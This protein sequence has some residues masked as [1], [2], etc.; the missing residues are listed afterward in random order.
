VQNLKSNVA[1]NIAGSSASKKAC[2]MQASVLRQAC[3]ACITYACVW[4]HLYS[5]ALAKKTFIE[6]FKIAAQFHEHYGTVV[7]WNVRLFNITSNYI[8]VRLELAFCARCGQHT[9][10]CI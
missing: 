5:S 4:L 2:V 1:I 9:S 10:C 6:V 3:A 8:T 7:R